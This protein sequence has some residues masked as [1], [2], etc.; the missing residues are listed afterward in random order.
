[1]IVNITR[2]KNKEIEA[3]VSSVYM[4]QL[5]EHDPYTYY[6]SV[7][8]GSIMSSFG[9]YL[10]CSSKEIE[11][12]YFAGLLH[13]IGKVSVSQK[14]LQKKGPLTQ[15]EWISIKAHP[16]DSVRRLNDSL[17]E[18]LI[19]QVAKYHHENMDGSGYPFG[20]KGKE[21]PFYARIARI[22]DTFDAITTE[23]AYSKKDSAGKAMHII[24]SEAGNLFDPVLAH[25]FKLFSATLS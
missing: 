13:D 25:K 19:H 2:S 17:A 9:E 20:I 18:P 1:M 16:I 21:I 14:I 23:R 4:Q 24:T 3:L 10:G 15:D 11:L 6:H 8:V 7:R 22:V 12:L 5:L